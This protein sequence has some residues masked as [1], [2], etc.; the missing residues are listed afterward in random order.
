MYVYCAHS[1]YASPPT[2]VWVDRVTGSWSAST[3]TWNN[4]PGSTNITSTQVYR[5]QWAV[6]DV[7]GVVKAWIDGTSTNYGF[8]LH[9]NG[10]GQTY[11]KKF[12]ASENSTNKPYLSITYRIPAPNAPTGCLRP[13]GWQ[14]RVGGPQVGSGT[15]GHG[16]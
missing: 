1:Y 2:G 8:K 5:G 7:T 11:W 10:N 9:T 15:G 16:L 14:L 6:F 4:K 3:L 12:Y 13:R